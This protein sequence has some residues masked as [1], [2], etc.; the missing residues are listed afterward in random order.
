ME[1]V[2]DQKKIL[3]LDADNSMMDAVADL[4]QTGQWEVLI[5]QNPVN[6]YDQALAYHPDLVVMDYRLLADECTGICNQLSN[7]PTLKPVP[8]IIISSKRSRKIRSAANNCE[9]IFLKPFDMGTL[10]PGMEYQMAC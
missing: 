10:I 7:D 5:T 3:L 8:L 2:K 6:V 9:A 4:L 1:I